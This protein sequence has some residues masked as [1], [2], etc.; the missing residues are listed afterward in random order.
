ML[1]RL[2]PR[3]EPFRST[4]L[5]LK[6]EERAAYERDG[7]VSEVSVPIFVAGTFRGSIGF[8]SCVDDRNWS[9]AEVET[10]WRASHMIGAYWRR[11]D[12][13]EELKA[14]NESKDRLARLGQP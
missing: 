7:I 12:D 1:S 9:E 14:S 5:A 2:S 4:P 6:G 10:L 13:Q 3:G 8:V 11:Q